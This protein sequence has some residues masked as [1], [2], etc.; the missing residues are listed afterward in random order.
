MYLLLHFT[1]HIEHE[2]FLILSVSDWLLKAF[3]VIRNPK[4]Y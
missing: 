2:C 1:Q 4:A 3:F